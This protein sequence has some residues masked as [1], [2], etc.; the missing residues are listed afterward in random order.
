MIPVTTFARKR[1]AVFGLGGSGIATARALIAG[2]ADVMAWDDSEASRAAA[3]EAE[4]DVIDWRGHEFGAFSAL[5]LAPGVP[6]THPAPHWS[7][8]IARDAGVEIIGDI[9]LFARERAQD[10]AHGTLRRHHRYQR[11]VDHHGPDR[12]HPEDGRARRATRRQH[13]DRGAFAGAAVPR[14]RPRA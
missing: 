10:S 14:A 6:L 7:V 4:I 1:V 13:R 2:G 5:V 3:A 12:P 11:Q 9:E 8:E